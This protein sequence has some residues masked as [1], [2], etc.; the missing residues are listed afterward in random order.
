MFERQNQS[1]L[2]PHYTALVSHEEDDDD[3][4]TLARR[5]HDLEATASG[6]GEGGSV[7]VVLHAE[8]TVPAD[9]L[10]KRKLKM[11][12]SKRGAVKL[13]PGPDKVV[14][15]EE[16][17]PTD[18]YK[19][20]AD[21]EAMAAA[22]RERFV[23]EENERM[24]EA[25]KIDREVAR[26]KKREKKRKRKEREREMMRDEDGASG[27]DDEGQV[28]VIGGAYQS[29]DSEGY[30]SE[31]REPR[32]KKSKRPQREASRDEVEDEEELALRLLRGE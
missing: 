29:D 7:P 27:D 10:S 32:G 8:G 1:V 6:S 23:R 9:D 30:E 18:F 19:A 21:A 3:L 13:R 22:E 5:D 24:R 26:E 4:F 11:A 15:D 12:T 20:G 28:A 31:D 14:F 16:G 25:D 17:L 2:T